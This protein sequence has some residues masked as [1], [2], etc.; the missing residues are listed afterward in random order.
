MKEKSI[1]VCSQCGS[2]SVK[3]M[4][5]CPECGEFGTMLEEK[6]APT[7]NAPRSSSFRLSTHTYPVP[8]MGQE[9]SEEI[10]YSTG[11]PEFDRVLGGGSVRGSVVLIGGEPGI[12]KSTLLLQACYH[13]AREGQKVLL[14]S[15]E[16]SPTQVQMRARRLGALAQNLFLYCET[17]VEVIRESVRK[18]TPQ[19]LV[20][21]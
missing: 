11:M 7:S 15:G 1:F 20:V 12:G 16:E 6:S 18:I 10:Y 21:E 13:M 3:W 14:V 19:V 8:L 2:V 9:I 5:R 17:D 4:G